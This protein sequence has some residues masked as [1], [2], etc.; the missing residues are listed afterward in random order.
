MKH[1]RKRILSLLMSGIMTA[2]LLPAYLTELP[3]PAAADDPMEDNDPTIDFD[4]ATRNNILNADD[5]LKDI[6]QQKKD[7]MSSGET[8]ELKQRFPWQHATYV[9][10]EGDSGHSLRTLLESTDTDDQYV[11][12]VKIL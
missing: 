2:S 11:S 8:E 12:L 6:A 10:A 9:T 5:A 1:T 3:I 7:S 4:Y